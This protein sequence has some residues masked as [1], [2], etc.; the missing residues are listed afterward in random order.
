VILCESQLIIHNGKP[1]SVD[2]ELRE[3]LNEAREMEME[4]QLPQILKA[5]LA[6]HRHEA[7]VA[8]LN[9][10]NCRDKAK[11][12]EALMNAKENQVDLSYI[13]DAAA[14]LEQIEK[15]EQIPS[16]LQEAIDTR[17]IVM[18]TS[19]LKQIESIGL[20]AR[21][22]T[23]ASLVAQAEQV[24]REAK[25]WGEALEDAVDSSDFDA[26]RRVSVYYYYYYYYTPVIC[27]KYLLRM[28][29]PR[30]CKLLTLLSNLFIYFCM[31]FVPDSSEPQ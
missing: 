12:Q 11:L 25:E 19:L 14:V 30:Q 5:E 29:F 18:L 31:L 28:L 27:Q 17:N 4:P 8:L 24:I 15:E 6:L 26:I 1:Q 23:L 10:I 20:V 9:A 22:A 7:H 3:R 13:K 16:H 2:A 21:V